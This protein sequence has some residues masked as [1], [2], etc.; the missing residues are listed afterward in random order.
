MSEITALFELQ[1]PAEVIQALAA[2]KDDPA[3]QTVAFIY[4]DL[5]DRAMIGDAIEGC[6]GDIIVDMI[7]GWYWAVRNK[8]VE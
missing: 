4:R 8:A 5:T 2:R 6:D 3:A 7:A 1:D